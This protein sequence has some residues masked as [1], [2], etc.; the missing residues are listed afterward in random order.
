[1]S[2]KKNKKV[3]VN[4]SSYIDVIMGSAVR[5]IAVVAYALSRKYGI[6]PDLLVKRLFFDWQSKLTYNI[7]G[8]LD[9]EI[10]SFFGPE[11]FI[12]AKVPNDKE[13]L[14]KLEQMGDLWPVPEGWH[15][16]PGAI[17]ENMG[18]CGNPRLGLVL[19]LVNK[20]V[21]KRRLR[22][23]IQDAIAHARHDQLVLEGMDEGYIPTR[24]AIK[25]QLST[26]GATGSGTMHWLL[27]EDGIRS[28]AKADGV[29]SNVILQIICRGNL[30]AYDNDKADLNEFLNLRHL[31]VLSTGAYIKSLTGTTQ[32][33][34]YD[35][36]FLS[37]NQN[38]NGNMTSLDQLLMHQGQGDHL[39]YH[40]PAG[41][42]MRERLTDILAIQYNEYG[43]PQVGFTM[44]CAFLSR[45]S[46]RMLGFFGYKAAAVLANA[47]AAQGDAEKLR[48]Y[49]TGLA[50]QYSII[51]SEED[52]QITRMI[53]HPAEL[54]N[55]DV[56]ERTRASFLD[57]VRHSQGMQR[58]IGADSSLKS[59]LNGDIT[60][61]YEPCMHKQAQMHTKVTINKLEKHLITT[62]RT[63]YGLWESQYLFGSLKLIVERSFQSL[64]EKEK[65]LKEYQ[66]P[67]EQILAEASERVNILH[68]NNRLINSFNYPLIRR[69][70]MSLEE[71]GQAAIGYQLQIAACQIAANDVLMPL[72]D[73]IDCK[74][75]WLSGMNHNL[76]QV[77]QICENKAEGVAAKPTILNVPLGIELATPEYLNN[78]FQNHVDK[79]GGKDKF[80]TYLLSQF[81]KKHGSLALLADASIEEYEEAFTAVCED[82]FRP[83]TE[84]TDVISEFQK[85]Y[86]QKSKQ[87]KIIE[88]LIKESEGGLRTTGESSNSVV[89]I[90]GA[91][92]T[93]HEH[94]EWLREILEKV[95][96]KP[97]KW[98]V[99]VHN[100]PD[101]IGIAQLRGSI[102]LQ[103]LIDRIA[104]SDDPEGWA[105]II[106]IAPDPVSVLIVG[107]N[108]S[109]RQLRRVLVKAIADGQLNVDEKGRYIL[110]SSNSE[111][112]ILDKTFESV[113]ATLRSKWSELVFI[114][115][116]FGRNLV[117]AEEQIIS[118]LNN[119]KAEIQSNNSE[120][121]PRLELINLNSV[122]ECLKQAELLLPRLRRMRKANQKRLPYETQ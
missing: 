6:K 102:S 77:A 109:P 34:P 108:P 81:L 103:S 66:R 105:K 99:A 65:E 49:A 120:P 30:Q 68:Q 9:L 1:M 82:I 37:S 74:L 4:P 67:H 45:D 57:R 16:N 121:D 87:R 84:N 40:T 44:S 88:R 97:S 58:A 23:I 69:L 11:D 7:D 29:E 8:L 28:C 47:V 71:S 75:A 104:P 26:I 50:R 110:N 111:P 91:N 73:Y 22:K 31:Q 27:G 19:A 60:T 62:M 36:L 53:M 119:L 17:L 76:I 14:E 116:T 54:G 95:D 15:Q 55:E 89:W 83:D 59:I 18:A 96:K 13:T 72:L 5:T 101:R 61:T 21:I 86:P 12:E 94:V 80:A 64:L 118:K 20:R 106:D 25:L 24:I 10:E 56:V 112:L 43:E 2:D 52:N 90:K 3:I 70:S 48:R 100:D 85:L 79:L 78:S 93:S 46:S 39:L 41:A 117:V 38:C 107:P 51:E 63:T 35:A 115:S 113:K 122:E 42:K 114:E 92:V 33:I 32:P 98:E